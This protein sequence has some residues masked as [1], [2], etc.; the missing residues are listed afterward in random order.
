MVTKMKMFGIL[1]NDQVKNKQTNKS[2]SS[3]SSDSQDPRSR[4]RSR[5]SQFNMASI[6]KTQT[7]G[8]KSCRG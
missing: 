1:N 7:T 2:A 4:S 8:C 5:S 3:F 6:M